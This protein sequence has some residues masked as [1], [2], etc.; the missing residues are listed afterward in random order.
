MQS[1]RLTSWRHVLSRVYGPVSV[2]LAPACQDEESL[3]PLGSEYIRIQT[4]PAVTAGLAHPFECYW[5]VTQ[6]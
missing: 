6:G 5:T 4:A 1:M 3:R 2:K